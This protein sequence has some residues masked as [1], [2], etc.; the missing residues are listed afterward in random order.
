MTF[1]LIYFVFP[2]ESFPINLFFKNFISSDGFLLFLILTFL[3]KQVLRSGT[4][5]NTTF[6]RNI[7]VYYPQ[8]RINRFNVFPFSG[9]NAHMRY[10]FKSSVI[11][12]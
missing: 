9:V 10:I 6:T 2:R 12:V 7:P 3:Y 8:S 1:C 5:H 11:F 4:Q